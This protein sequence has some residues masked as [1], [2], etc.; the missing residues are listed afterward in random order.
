[1]DLT[2]LSSNPIRIHNCGSGDA[3]TPAVLLLVSLLIYAEEYRFN[4]HENLDRTAREIGGAERIKWHNPF[5]KH[6]CYL[7]MWDSNLRDKNL[8]SF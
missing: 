7:Q 1:M 3:E 5:T 4:E 6:Y 8:V 2:L